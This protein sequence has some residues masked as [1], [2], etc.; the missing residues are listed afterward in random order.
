MSTTGWGPVAVALP[1]LPDPVPPA[2]L[3][4]VGLG[5]SGLAAI[6]EGLRLGLRVVGIDAAGVA[7]GASGRN[8]GFLLAGRADFF[9]RTVAAI[10]SEAARAIY[11][12]TVAEIHRM[13]AETPECVRPVGSL[14]VAGSTEEEDDLVDHYTALRLAGV[15]VERRDTPWGAGLFLADDAAFDPVTRAAVLATRLTAA[16]AQLFRGRVADVTML[17]AP[18]VVAVDGGLER[19]VP[20]LAGRVRT[21]RLQMLASAP[22]AQVAV[23]QPIYRRWGF[24]YWQQRPDG[25]VVVGGQR[26]QFEAAEWIDAGR[27]AAPEPTAGVQAALDELLRA[28]VGITDAPVTHR[29]AG[30]SGFTPDHRPICEPVGDGVVAVGGYSG[31]GNVIGPLCGRAAVQL[32]LTGTSALAATLLA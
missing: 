8:G 10:G 32:L 28:V 18:T 29:W 16:G 1:P 20:A 17:P 27:A 24:D 13:A 15:A 30:S 14:R 4:V 9:H 31:T 26:D 7:G 6:A 22:T 12:V 3:Y 19:V 25:T 21:A 23:T 11:Q 5:G 2:E